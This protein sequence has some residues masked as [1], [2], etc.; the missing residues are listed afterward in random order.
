[1]VR[2]R[3]TKRKQALFLEAIVRGSSVVE[4]CHYAGI[5]RSTAY[6]WAEDEAFEEAWLLAE[7]GPKR[8]LE[9]RAFELAM[10]EGAAVGEKPHVRLITF[11]LERYDRQGG[12]VGAARDAESE[13]VGQIDIRL[14][15]EGETA[16]G[17]FISFVES[18]V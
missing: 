7:E 4:A 8:E 2:Q 14:L 9:R 12:V 1:M 18:G 6:Q 16:E 17:G 13:S 11:L 15:G 5:A 10:G 3:G